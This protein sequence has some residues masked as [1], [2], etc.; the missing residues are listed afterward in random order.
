MPKKIFDPELA[1][2][3]DPRAIRTREGL[4]RALLQLLESR[5]L[6]HVSIRDI[7]KRSRISYTTF[8][9]HYPSKEALLDDL[10]A[11]QIRRMIALAITVMDAKNALAASEALFTYIEEHRSIWSTLLTGAATALRK[12]F[13]RVAGGVKA[14]MAEPDIWPPAELS[15]LLSVTGTIE[16]MTWWLKQ[17]DPLPVAEI[18]RLHHLQVIEP[19]IRQIRRPARRSPR[20]K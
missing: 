15:M 17:P 7:A 3:R 5:P 13:L 20:R 10:A 4:R 16:M 12:E 6:E 18:A 14:A 1:R 2:T 11:E 9:R 19:S 8:F